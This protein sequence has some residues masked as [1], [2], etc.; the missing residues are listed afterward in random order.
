LKNILKIETIEMTS[1]QLEFIGN[2][3][4]VPSVSVFDSLNALGF[5]TQFK[6]TEQGL[7]SLST[8]KVFQ[9]DE[10]EVVHFF[11]FE[12]DSN[13]SDSSIVYAIKTN[14]GEKGTLVD[15]YG[16]YNDIYVTEFMQK[17]EEIHK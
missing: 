17:V 7:L 2:I 6:A 4:R 5:E 16:S 13:P 9:P 11:R 15:G 8:K 1:K 3:N 10:I 14:D 12:G